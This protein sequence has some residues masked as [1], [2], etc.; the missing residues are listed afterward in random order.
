MSAPKNQHLDL[1]ISDQSFL[2]SILSL[3]M[4][5]KKSHWFQVSASELLED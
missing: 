5:K 2:V 3:L 1:L 4:H